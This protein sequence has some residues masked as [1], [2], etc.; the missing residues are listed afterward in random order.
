MSRPQLTLQ[1][2]HELLHDADALRV[3]VKQHMPTRK[4]PRRAT[5]ERYAFWRQRLLGR[6]YA[7]CLLLGGYPR[8][9]GT[10]DV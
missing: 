2:L 4:P 10:T 1:Q 6:L 7:R 9:G 8:T 3:Y 5:R